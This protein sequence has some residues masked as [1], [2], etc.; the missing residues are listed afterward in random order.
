MR[1]ASEIMQHFYN[2]ER[3]L[4]SS[5]PDKPDFSEIQKVLSPNFIGHQ[6]P[7][8]AYGGTYE[9]HEGFRRWAGLM[10]G[11]FS[12]IDAQPINTLENGDD[13]VILTTVH[14]TVR[15]TGEDASTL[16]AQH[17]KVDREEGVIVEFRPYYW[18]VAQINA[19]LGHKTS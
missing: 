15:K 19:L 4:M 2:A 1:T 13:I 10:G 11:Y 5:P 18:D 12:K 9:G 16:M 7:A 6:S 14:F 3:I 17:V 8:L